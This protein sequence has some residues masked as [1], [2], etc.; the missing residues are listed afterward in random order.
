ME[1]L[2]ELFRESKLRSLSIDHETDSVNYCTVPS[3]AR[4]VLKKK[5]RDL[6]RNAKSMHVSSLQELRKDCRDKRTDIFPYTSLLKFI[7]RKITERESYCSV[8][9]RLPVPERVLLS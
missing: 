4:R 9:S 7:A 6:P 1:Q 3:R 5:T 8:D 2:N